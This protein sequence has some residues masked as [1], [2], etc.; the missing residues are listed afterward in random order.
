MSMFRDLTHAVMESITNPSSG[1]KDGVTAQNKR[2][3]AKRA[4]LNAEAEANAAAA[5]ADP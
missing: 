5:A 2:V 1:G 4:A 3:L